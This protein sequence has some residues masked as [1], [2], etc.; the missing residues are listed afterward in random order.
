MIVLA[1]SRQVRRVFVVIARWTLEN[2]H[3]YE[4]VR[5][6]FDAVFTYSLLGHCVRHRL[7]QFSRILL[8]LILLSFVL[9]LNMEQN[10]TDVIIKTENLINAVQNEPSIWNSDLQRLDHLAMDFGL[11]TTSLLQPESD[12][13]IHMAPCRLLC[14]H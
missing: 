14:F 3:T 9:L 4:P 5:H 1:G 12:V 8:L 2:D 11:N 7:R 10:S 13:L 6:F